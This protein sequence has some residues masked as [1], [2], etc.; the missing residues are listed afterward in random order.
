LKAKKQG[1]LEKVL[2]GINIRTQKRTKRDLLDW[3]AHHNIQLKKGT[4]FS[5]D[6][7]E[8]LREIYTDHH[9]HEVYRKAA[10]VGISI[11]HVLKALW[12]SDQYVLKSLYYFPTDDAIADFSVDRLDPIIKQTE[13][14]NDRVQEAKEEGG[15][16]NR[17][18]KHL[19]QS[20]I[21]MRGMFTRT[22]VKSVDGD[23]LI[24]DELDE[25]NQENREF[26]FDR[27]M[28]SW[29]Q[30]VSELSQPSLQDYGID[31]SFNESDQ[32]FWLLRCPA[33]GQHN[34]LEEDFPKNFL[35]ARDRKG[36]Y[37]GCLKCGAALD[38]A[39]GE[40]VPKYPGKDKRGYHLSQ[41][42][43]EICPQN[44]ADPAD[45]IMAEH[46]SA[47]KTSEKK[48]FTISRLGYPYAGDRQP[49]TDR[50]LDNCEANYDLGLEAG[51]ATG[52]G[53][54]VGDTIHVVVRGQDPVSG[55]ARIIWIESTEDWGRLGEIAVEFKVPVF[56]I[57]AMPYKAS[58]KALVRAFPGRGYLQYFKEREKITAEGEF[59]KEVPVVH[60]DRTESL[61]DTTGEFRQRDIEI[62]AMAGLWEESL[63]RVE[64]L[65]GQLKT[66]VKDLVQRANGATVAVYKSN[67]NNHYGM[68]ANSAR[69]AE[70]LGPLTIWAPENYQSA[71]PRI[72]KSQLD[73][74]YGG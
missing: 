49:I 41:L 44:V 29:L 72:T 19:G 15:A 20:T 1:S 54:D 43:T 7:H 2:A 33:C 28:H 48:R 23:Y 14:L 65:R 11:Y 26:A 34:S 31:K 36:Y 12:M 18:L 45:K 37:R 47:R 10:Q 25:A 24:L 8:Y 5:L 74:V 35:R 63:A 73:K 51:R 53:I 55:R 64:D 22:S 4:P 69:I 3:I 17:G 13:Y 62:P 27:I 9:P 39:A 30:W 6:G 59:E 21:Y 40:W 71:G 60:V 67:V 50:V 52:M 16:F 56:V 46:R 57:D 68:A 66:L 32:R 42:Y 70:E 38:M 61:D 58:A